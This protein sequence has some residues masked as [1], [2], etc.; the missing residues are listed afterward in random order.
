VGHLFRCDADVLDDADPDP[1]ASQRAG[2]IF[3]MMLIFPLMMVAELLSVRGD[4]RLD[5]AIAG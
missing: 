2:N 3:T 5:G 1:A 4:A